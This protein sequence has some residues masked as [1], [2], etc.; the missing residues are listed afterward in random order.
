MTKKQIMFQHTVIANYSTGGCR[1]NLLLNHFLNEVTWR[2][3]HARVE[4]SG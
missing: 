3:E 2:I 4:R 1:S